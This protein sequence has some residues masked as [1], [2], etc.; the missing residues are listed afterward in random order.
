GR[1]HG[2]DA[3]RGDEGGQGGLADPDMA[4]DLDVLDPAFGDQAPDEPGLGSHPLCRLLYRQQ[5]ISRVGLCW[6]HAALPVAET[7][8]AR[9]SWA[10]RLASA[11]AFSHW[12]RSATE[13]SNRLPD[14]R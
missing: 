14:G 12:R 5:L 9:A 4:A 3:A 10:R 2:L 6:H 8:A 11:R 13:R 7:S 1:S